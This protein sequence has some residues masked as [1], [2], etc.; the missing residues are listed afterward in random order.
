MNPSPPESVQ[1]AYLAPPG[2]T[3]RLTGELR[4]IRAH[5]GRLILTDGPPQP[6]FW[7]QNIWFHP[8]RIAIR[9]ITDGAR[10]LKAIQRN[11]GLYST[12]LHRRAALIQEQLPHVSAKPLPFPSP[13]PPSPL[14]SWTLLDAHTILASPACSSLFPNGEIQFQEDRTGPPNRAYLKLWEALTLLQK[15]PGP[16]DFCIDAGASPGGWTWTLQKLGAQVLSIDRSP[17]NSKI[18]SLPRVEFRKGNALGLNPDEFLRHDQKV[19]W[20]LSDVVCY[21]E[22]LYEWVRP[23]VES[24]IC[25][26]FLCTIKFQGPYEESPVRKFAALPGSRIIHLHHNKNELT[27]IRVKET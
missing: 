22:K 9:S 13:L 4:D 10:Q 24:G 21:P 8:R 14:G 6:A 23:W 17:L 18:A 15:Y 2:F 11:W 1:T 25:D 19:D 3:E 16:G 27:W 12:H 5:Y 20:L 26:H 7:A